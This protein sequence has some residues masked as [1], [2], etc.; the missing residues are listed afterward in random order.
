MKIWLEKSTVWGPLV[1]R[2]WH[3]L[4]CLHVK[5]KVFIAIVIPSNLWS[6]LRERLKLKPSL[7]HLEPVLIII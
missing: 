6:W 4:N 3:R 1:Y 7:I 5:H 2:F